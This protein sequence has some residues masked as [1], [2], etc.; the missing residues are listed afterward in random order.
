M[1]KKLLITLS[2]L[3]ALIVSPIY[4]GI[5]EYKRQE[6]VD[7]SNGDPKLRAFYTCLD[8]QG[9]NQNLNCSSILAKCQAGTAPVISFDEKGN[10]LIDG[11]V[12]GVVGAAAWNAAKG[13]FK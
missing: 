6:I 5:R 3:G 13:I 4:W 9:I 10:P 12:G 11:A 8:K 2:I 7:M 1:S